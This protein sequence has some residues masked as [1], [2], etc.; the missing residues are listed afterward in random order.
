MDTQDELQHLGRRLRLWR[1]EH[2]APT[3]IPADIWSGAAQLAVV[4]GVGPVA[5][6]LRLDYSRLKKLRAQRDVAGAAL[7]PA[8]R[9]VEFCPMP[10]DG[11][12][13]CFLEVESAAGAKMR[14]QL[15]NPQ[16]CSLSALIRDFVA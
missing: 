4:L 2:S 3:P 8:A 9:F 7:R 11:L 10:M 1:Q 16:C 13:Q 12:G 14:I 15:E 6:T 5:K